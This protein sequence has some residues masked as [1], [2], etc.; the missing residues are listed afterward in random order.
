MIP[1]ETDELILSKVFD[2][3]ICWSEKHT[4]SHSHTCTHMGTHAHA[5]WG[6]RDELELFDLF[7]ENCT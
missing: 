5:L 4:H 2:F 3:F 7:V 6:V 1:I